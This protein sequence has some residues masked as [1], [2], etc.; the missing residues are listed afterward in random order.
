MSGAVGVLAVVKWA[1]GHVASGLARLAFGRWTSMRNVPGLTFFKL[2]GSG[3]EGGFLI[4]PGLQYQGL[5]CAFADE[6]SADAFLAQSKMMCAYRAHGI[7]LF[8]TKLRAYSSRG[9]WSHRT[10][11]SVTAT[12]P[13]VGPV[14]SL[15]RASIK[16]AKARA[17]WR[18]SP[19]TQASLEAAEGR[20]VSMGLGEAPVFRQA[21]FTIWENQEAMDRFARSGAH[22]DA[23]KVARANKYFSED[24]FARFVPY[25]MSGRWKG[26]SF[27]PATSMATVAA[28]NE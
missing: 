7:E 18:H 15:T 25:E 20:I 1:P 11:L 21:T 17:F 27:G 14:A 16:P 4:Q 12:S 5:F 24:L 10:P 13:A 23:I 8:Q 26:R 3:R 9:S 2:L 28:V 22:L 19:H 6:V